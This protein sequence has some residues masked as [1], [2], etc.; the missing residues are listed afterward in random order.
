MLQESTITI[1]KTALDVD[2]A[3]TKEE[4]ERVLAA[5]NPQERIAE[6]MITTKEACEMLDVSRRTLAN[7]V[8]E[9]KIKIIKY[10]PRQV[11][12][13]YAE[14]CDFMVGKKGE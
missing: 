11:R 14:V 2:T 5:L 8:Q 3:I 10:S 13:R 1:I 4:K 6:K 7:Y 12:Y 9:G